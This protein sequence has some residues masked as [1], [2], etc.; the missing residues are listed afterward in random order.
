MLF[1]PYSKQIWGRKTK[2]LLNIHSRR[3]K[4]IIQTF[5]FSF[6][7]I[8]Y[9]E[10]QVA[11]ITPEIS[12]KILS[13]ITQVHTFSNEHGRNPRLYVAELGEDSHHNEAKVYIYI[14]IYNLDIDNGNNVRRSRI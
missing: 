11:G 1:T 13:T 9:E 2:I 12:N 14:Y 8:Q 3:I 7:S 10:T 5:Y 6:S 4:N